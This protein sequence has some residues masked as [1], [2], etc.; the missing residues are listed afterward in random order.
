VSQNGASCGGNP[1]KI[2]VSGESAGG[3]LAAATAFMARDKGTPVVAAQLLSQ[4]KRDR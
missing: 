4:C 2:I 1:E 3:N